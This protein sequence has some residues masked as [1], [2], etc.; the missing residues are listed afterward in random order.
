MS[1]FGLHQFIIRRA[2]F[3]AAKPQHSGNGRA[4]NIG[5]QQ[6]D[7]STFQRQGCCDIDC[8]SRFTHPALAGR[9]QNNLLNLFKYRRGCQLII[10]RQLIVETG[11][12]QCLLQRLC[13][14]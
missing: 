4:I 14:R 2:D 6:A 13:Y 9:Y 3:L 7:F 5:I 8:G 1:K 10:Q 11:I 12:S